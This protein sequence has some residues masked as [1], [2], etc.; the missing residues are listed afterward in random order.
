MCSL[1]KIRSSRLASHNQH[2]YKQL[3]VSEELCCI[4]ENRETG[5]IIAL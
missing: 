2:I 4:D 5:L 1:K 3:Y